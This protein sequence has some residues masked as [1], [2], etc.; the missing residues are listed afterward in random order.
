MA[1]TW[2]FLTLSM[3]LFHVSTKLT[4]K[5]QKWSTGKWSTG[6]H[7]PLFL[8]YCFPYTFVPSLCLGKIWTIPSSTK[9]HRE[10]EIYISIYAFLSH[11]ADC[12]VVVTSPPIIPPPPPA[13]LKLPPALPPSSDSRSEVGPDCPACVWRI[14]AVRDGAPEKLRASIARPVAIAYC[15]E[16]K[17]RRFGCLSLNAEIIC[18]D[19]LGTT[20][21]K[22]ARQTRGS[23]SFRFAHP[24]ASDEVGGASCVGQVIVFGSGT[25]ARFVRPR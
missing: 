16:K 1:Q 2:R 20:Q 12:R 23:V 19:R 8:E 14:A 6:K 24:A 4:R 7:P 25:A 22:R 11:L 13:E 17:R 18:Q 21:R 9:W 15:E 3:N 5:L 10:R